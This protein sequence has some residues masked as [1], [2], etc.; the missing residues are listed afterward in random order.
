MKRTGVCY[1]ALISQGT[2]AAGVGEHKATQDWARRGREDHELQERG[3]REGGGDA[4]ALADPRTTLAQ[5]MLSDL[6]TRS[7]M[8]DVIMPNRTHESSLNHQRAET[9]GTVKS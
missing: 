1:T 3:T 9:G 5:R 4:A 7:L 8:K 6:P 2:P